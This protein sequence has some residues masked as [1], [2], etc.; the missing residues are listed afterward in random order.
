MNTQYLRLS[1]DTMIAPA[2]LWVMHEYQDRDPI[3][4]VVQELTMTDT[5]EGYLFTREGFAEDEAEVAAL[6]M[7]FALMA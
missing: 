1:L 6:T 4:D 2:T 7:T 5:I 3:S